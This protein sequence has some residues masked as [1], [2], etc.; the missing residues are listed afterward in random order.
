MQCPGPGQSTKDVDSNYEV[1][2]TKDTL[3]KN[4]VRPITGKPLKIFPKTVFSH[5]AGSVVEGQHVL[6]LLSGKSV[7]FTQQRLID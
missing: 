1:F 7:F 6:Y 5:I 4:F 3:V 2:V